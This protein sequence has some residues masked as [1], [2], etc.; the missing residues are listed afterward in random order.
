MKLEEK[1]QQWANKITA[2]NIRY[3][4]T[5]PYNKVNHEKITKSK[6]SNSICKICKQKL[7]INMN[8]Y[9]ALFKSS[10]SSDLC[11]SCV[12]TIIEY[13]KINPY[14]TH[15]K[16]LIVFAEC[17]TKEAFDRII[18]KAKTMNHYPFC[19]ILI[20]VYNR[21]FN[22]EIRPEGIKNRLSDN[23]RIDVIGKRSGTCIGDRRSDLSRNQTTKRY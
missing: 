6:Y 2:K 7:N 3:G 10:Y 14:S 5:I 11:K 22:Y 23:R 20:D 15:T 21:R 4:L 8:D 9:H 18:L 12:N 16:W 19:N 13:F 17:I 1:I